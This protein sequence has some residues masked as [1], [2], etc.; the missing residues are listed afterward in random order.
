MRLKT[1]PLAQI[2]P[3]AKT[4]IKNNM[5]DSTL[6]VEPSCLELVAKRM[7]PAAATTTG[8]AA[9]RMSVKK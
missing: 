1:L 2:I 7:D 5:K 3:P 6:V 8:G 9:I 4:S